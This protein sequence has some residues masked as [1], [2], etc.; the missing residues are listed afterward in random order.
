MSACSFSCRGPSPASDEGQ[1]PAPCQPLSTV[2]VH[3]TS[4]LLV[5]RQAELGN[6]A[7]PADTVIESVR[8][9]GVVSTGSHGTARDFGAVPDFVESLMAVDG[10]GQPV[11][12][13]SS[14]PFFAQVGSSMFLT[15]RTCPWRHFCTKSR[16]CLVL[17]IC[18]VMV[19]DKC[20]ALRR[21]AQ[22][23]D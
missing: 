16:A 10:R 17:Y 9:G 7:L 3:G 5:A 23:L 1:A 22:R 2:D 11:V 8:Y 13:K 19:E 6:A 15:S 21:R 4:R 18:R 12:Y 20:T 14:S